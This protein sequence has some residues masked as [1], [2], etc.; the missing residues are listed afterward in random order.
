MNGLS[1]VLRA[2]GL[3]NPRVQK[4][5]LGHCRKGNVSTVLR[6]IAEYVAAIQAGK[7]LPPNAGLLTPDL[8]AAA[9][10]AALDLAMSYNRQGG[11]LTAKGYVSVEDLGEAITTSWVRS[12]APPLNEKV[13]TEFTEP[14]AVERR[15]VMALAAKKLL[16]R[17][18][19]AE[20]YMIPEDR[21]EGLCQAIVMKVWAA[22]KSPNTANHEILHD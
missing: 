5:V 7:A 11:V 14:E 12:F 22:M 1:G 13:Y 10:A 3:H 16:D 20:G 19:N 18:K 9:S 17:Y 21:V 8:R 15:T 6:E 2:V 4:V